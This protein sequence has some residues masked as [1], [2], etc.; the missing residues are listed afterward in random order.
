[1]TAT[2]SPAGATPMP[3][4]PLGQPMNPMQVFILSLVTCGIYGLYWAY[5]TFEELKQHNGE[6]LGGVVGVITC[7]FWVGYFMLPIEIQKTYQAE[8]RPSPVEPVLGVWLLVPI[9]G[10][11]KYQTEVQ[12]A[13]NDYWVSKGAA[14]VAS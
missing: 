4:G 3:K 2:P 11:Y 10:M 1:M 6:G 13:L 14:P 9:Y 5:K 7:F 8:G 12:T